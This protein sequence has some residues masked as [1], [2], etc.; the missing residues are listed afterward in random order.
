MPH[1]SRT[2][3]VNLDTRIFRPTV[4]NNSDRN[5]KKNKVFFGGQGGN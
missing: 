1:G 4:E 2:D 3:T 5:Y